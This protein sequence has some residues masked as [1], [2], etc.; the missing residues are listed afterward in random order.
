MAETRRSVCDV[1]KIGRN[2]CMDF[3]TFQDWR[4]QKTGLLE[5]QMEEGSTFE[6]VWC[7]LPTL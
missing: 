3:C 1:K 7:R 4:K 5:G 2:L 6:G